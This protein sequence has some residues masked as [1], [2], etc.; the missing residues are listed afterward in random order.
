MSSDE[1]V[2]LKPQSSMAL[3]EQMMQH[4]MVAI[5]TGQYA[6]GDKLP[7]EVELC[8]QYGVSRITVRRAVQEFVNEGLLERKQGKGTFVGYPKTPICVMSLN[9]YQSFSRTY[10][11]NNTK[12]TILSKK[13]RDATAKEAK[14]L[15]I[16]PNAPVYELIR[17]MET[18]GVPRSLDRAVYD[19]KRL[20]G[21]LDHIKEGTST[22]ELMSTAYGLK[23]VRVEKEITATRAKQDEADTLQCKTGDTLFMVTK[24]T[25]D[26]D[27]IPNHCSF[28]LMC[29]DRVKMTVSFSQ[30]D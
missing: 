15:Q 6:P 27:D 11:S 30:D 4:L 25:Y 19:V 9:G 23:N 8:H 14:L 5:K 7:S 26:K 24:V 28:N 13:S 1:S 17:L 2:L 12:V 20:P 18:D 22:Y 21:F 3:Y 10:C 29:A 16:Q